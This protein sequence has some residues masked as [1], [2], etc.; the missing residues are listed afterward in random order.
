[1][2][3]L[4][5][6]YNSN[7]QVTAIQVSFSFSCTCIPQGCDISSVTVA[8]IIILKIL[9][10]SECLQCTSSALYVLLIQ[11]SQQSYEVCTIIIRVYC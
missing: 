9:T 7:I 3:H 8:I 4:M 11:S 5:N 10:L 2:F 6:T 1:M